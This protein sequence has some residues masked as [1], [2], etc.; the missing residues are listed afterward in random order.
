ME[1]RKSS[2]ASVRSTA[3]IAIRT[4]A[5]PPVLPKSLTA[6]TIKRRAGANSKRRATTANAA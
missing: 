2:E 6:A 3:P 5:V 4:D 1:Y